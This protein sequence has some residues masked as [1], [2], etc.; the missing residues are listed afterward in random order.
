MSHTSFQGPLSGEY[1]F[2]GAHASDG[3]TINYNLSGHAPPRSIRPFSTVP[4]PPDPKFVER[5]DVLLWLRVGQCCKRVF[6]RCRVPVQL[7][8]SFAH[9]SALYFVLPSVVLPQP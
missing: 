7:V 2:A 8:T 4:F 6:G 5:T 3:G 1:V 9:G